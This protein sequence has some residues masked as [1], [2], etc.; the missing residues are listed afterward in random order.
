MHED[1][2][3]NRDPRGPGERADDDACDL[4][5]EVAGDRGP[6]VLRMRGELDIAVAPA[7]LPRVP[8]LVAGAPGVVLDLTAVTFL[9]SA[10]LHV[11]FRIGRELARTGKQYGV[12][13]A[14]SAHVAKT[15]EM[16]RLEETARIGPTLDDVLAIL[17]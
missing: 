3:R 12:V 5:V 14:P 9:D 16:V 13:L 4:T 15:V 10:A 8:D 1:R 6:R 17:R 2:A 11:L 7:L